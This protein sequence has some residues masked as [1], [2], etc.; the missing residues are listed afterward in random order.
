MAAL[1]NLSIDLPRTL[2]RLKPSFLQRLSTLWQGFAPR[3]K[4]LIGAA[5]AIVAIALL[6]WVAIA[7]A[8]ATL[9]TAQTQRSALDAQLQQMQALQAQAKSLQALPKIKSAEA[10]RAL[11]AL[12][13]QRLG[14]TAQLSLAGNQATLTL[15]NASPDALAQFLG[16]ARAQAN[17]VPS[18]ARLRRSASAQT[19]DGTL[20]LL[21]P[22]A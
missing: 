18:Q 14:A 17:S 16:Q 3:E 10:A 5:L 2:P 22:A 6:W 12:V 8:L 20:V 1:P 9:K 7:P 19:W 11:E 21:L 4:T 13:K 15:S